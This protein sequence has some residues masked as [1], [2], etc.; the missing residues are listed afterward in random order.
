MTL[1]FTYVSMI[2]AALREDKMT[3][4]A[5]KRNFM[6]YIP[7]MAAE[8][9]RLIFSFI[10]LDT[11]ITMLLDARPYLKRNS[12]RPADDVQDTLDNDP[13]RSLFTHTQIT[14]IYRKGFL[15][16]LFF[17]QHGRL[18]N[19]NT[20][21]TQMAPQQGVI[22]YPIMSNGLHAD[23]ELL[24][25]NH[26]IVNILRNFSE[27]FPIRNLKITQNPTYT[28]VPNSWV[29]IA[30]LSLLSDTV[31]FNTNIDH[32]LRKKAFDFIIA[33]DCFTRPKMEK[34]KKDAEELL[35]KVSLLKLSQ[36][37]RI[38]L[39]RRKKV[40]LRTKEATQRTKILNRMLLKRTKE[41]AQR[42]K[43]AAQRTKEAAQR[44]KAAAKETAQRTKTAAQRTK[45]LN[46]MLLKRDRADTLR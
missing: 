46:R 13:F 5:D 7:M 28:W 20:E 14:K 2:D 12:T 11:R 6:Q 25:F 29:P 3:P 43:E 31:T 41:A 34:K 26:P 18:Q 45:I 4:S 15:R 1:T 37:A 17:Y 38:E 23:P 21:I 22:S 10:D 9:R 40:T 16:K 30:A 19:V 32:Y 35:R 36:E 33:I 24:Y 44:T 27:R 42:T 39:K 8:L